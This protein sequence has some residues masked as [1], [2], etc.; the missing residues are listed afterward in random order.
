MFIRYPDH[1]LRLNITSETHNIER[2]L[3]V[4]SVCSILSP[5]SKGT[6]W[7][8][9]KQ[10]HTRRKELHLQE[11][12]SLNRDTITYPA[13][14]IHKV[15]VPWRENTKQSALTPLWMNNMLLSGLWSSS[16]CENYK[17]TFSHC[18]NIKQW[19]GLGVTNGVVP[20]QRVFAK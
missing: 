16:L 18:F 14:S 2:L 4:C 8:H 3:C 20:H 15:F 11:E 6:G 1:H 17:Q 7:M 5:Y 13:L 19:C 12:I 9:V 10:F